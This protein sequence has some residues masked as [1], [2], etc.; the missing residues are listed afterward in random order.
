MTKELKPNRGASGTSGDESESDISRR[1]GVLKWIGEHIAGSIL[2]LLVTLAVTG[3]IAWFFAKG[4]PGKQVDEL[5]ASFESEGYTVE[6]READLHAGAHSYV[7]VLARPA[8]PDTD[9]AK[10]AVNQIRIYDD[11]DGSLEER[12]SFQPGNA[13]LAGA[14]Y[15]LTDFIISSEEDLD[16]DGQAEL[17]GAYRAPGPQGVMVPVAIAWDP[18]GGYQINPLLT[19]RTPAPVDAQEFTNPFHLEDPARGRELRGW[20]V[21]SY[22]IVPWTPHGTVLAGEVPHQLASG[23]AAAISF[24]YLNFDRDQP[25]SALLCVSL[26]PNQ[27]RYEDHDVYVVGPAAVQSAEERRILSQAWRQVDGMGAPA[28]DDITKAADR[29][30]IGTG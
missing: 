28:T 24:W 5:V 17:V 4:S 29:G 9:L 13:Q 30:C 6:R 8:S 15:P 3:G 12:F 27:G 22:T 18:A 10:T 16:A 11:E 26:A 1:R 14:G 20:A 25:R 21:R 7:F 23:P 2:G 19:D